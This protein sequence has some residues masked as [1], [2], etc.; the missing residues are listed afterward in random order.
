M[1][2]TELRNSDG[3]HQPLVGVSDWVRRIQDEISC[4]APFPSN[5]LISGPTGTGKELIARAIHSQSPRSEKPF[6]PVNCAALTPSIFESLMFG[7][8]KGAF[9]GASF[10]ALGSFR[11]ADGG[12]IFLDE[13]GEIQLDLQAKLLRTLQENVVLPVGSHQEQPVDVRV[14]AATN[15]KLVHEMAEGRFREDLYY[16]LAVVSLQTVSLAQR[17]EDISILSQFLISQL[18]HG[19]RMPFKPLSSGAELRLRQH[20]WPGNVRELRNVLER[21]LML[22][23]SSLVRPDD[24]VFDGQGP[25][26][27]VDLVPAADPGSFT[28]AWPD[29]LDLGP[30]M[31]V[32]TTGSW[33]TMQDVERWH[34][35]MTL[36]HTNYNQ[37][38]AARILNMHRGSLYRRIK[39]YGLDVSG[40]NRG[41]PRRSRGATSPGQPR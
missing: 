24:I 9:T 17:P 26:A 1:P 18:C 15:R 5:V 22:S 21:A 14:V 40:S 30:E 27:P 34:L 31:T 28:P 33:P 16:R 32:S 11:A 39:Q 25:R 19:N 7:H 41:R 2:E 3:I 10:A 23:D 29:S 37:A 20:H 38:E 36:E 4:V 8:L 13:I 35:Q 12:T 6:V